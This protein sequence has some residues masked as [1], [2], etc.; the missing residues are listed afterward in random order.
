MG[1]LAADVFRSAQFT[2]IGRTGRD[3]DLRTFD[4]GGSKAKNRIAVNQG[5][6]VESIWFSVEAWDEAA[7]V[8]ADVTKGQMIR[9]TGRV[10]TETYQ[11][12]NGEEATD[13]VIKASYVEVLP[14]RG[15]DRQP[16]PA[17]GRQQQPANTWNASPGDFDDDSEIPF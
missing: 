12:R 14:S 9:V 8:L 10:T 3:S 7:M 17:R 6:D 5:K 16:A 2:F 4:N 11:K 15:G 13:N 1:Q